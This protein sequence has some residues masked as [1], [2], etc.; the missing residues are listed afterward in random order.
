M[1]C[2]GLFELDRY[3]HWLNYCSDRLLKLS[4]D[5]YWLILKTMSGVQGKVIEMFE[6]HSSDMFSSYFGLLR[7]AT[8][9]TT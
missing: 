7:K 2:E 3:K 9:I 1:G 6:M 5:K 4:C 8:A